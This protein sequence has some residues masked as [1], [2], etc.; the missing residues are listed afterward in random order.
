[1]VP[2][3]ANQYGPIIKIMLIRQAVAQEQRVCD[4]LLSIVGN[5]IYD[6]IAAD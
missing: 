1:M 3:K 4:D 6:S 2:H 5:V